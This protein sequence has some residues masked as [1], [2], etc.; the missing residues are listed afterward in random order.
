MRYSVCRHL[1][2]VKD[3]LLSGNFEYKPFWEFSINELELQECMPSE[4]EMQHTTVHTPTHT[5]D[6]QMHRN[7]GAVGSTL[8]DVRLA[9]GKCPLSRDC[10]GSV[11]QTYG[12]PSGKTADL[13]ARS[14]GFRES[15]PT[16]TLHIRRA[17]SV[18][19][20]SHSRSGSSKGPSDDDATVCN[21]PHS[22]PGI[23]H[24]SISY[25]KSG[26]K[27]LTHGDK[28]VCSIVSNISME[29]K[30]VDLHPEVQTA[31]RAPNA[32]ENHQRMATPSE[33]HGLSLSVLG[34]KSIEKHEKSVIRDI[35]VRTT[36]KEPRSWHV[37]QHGVG[38][39]VRGL[40]AIPENGSQNTLAHEINRGKQELSNAPSLL[41][42]RE[43][44]VTMENFAAKPQRNALGNLM[45]GQKSGSL[46]SIRAPGDTTPATK[47][48]SECAPVD[49]RTMAP[50]P[51][52]VPS[53]RQEGHA[54]TSTRR[55]VED[56]GM[57]MVRGI[58]YTKL[59]C[60][61]KGG[62]SKVYKVM[63]PNKKI[64]ALKRIRLNGR[65]SEAASGF[66]DEI[67]LLTRLKGKSNIIQLIDSE[68]HQKDGIIYMVLECGDIDLARLLQRHEASKQERREALGDSKARDSSVEVDE[69]FVRLYWEQMLLAVDT[70]HKE[71]I[72]HSDLKPANFLVVEGQLKLIDFGIAKAIQAGTTAVDLCVPSQSHYLYTIL[73][74]PYFTMIVD[75]T[76]IARE[77]QV[78]TL[79]YMSP[80]AITGGT[81]RG[82]GPP[83]KVGR[84]SDIWSLGCILYQMVY[85]K[86]PF[87]H[88]P[89]IQ[90]MHAIIDEKHDIKFPPLANPYLLHVIKRCLVRHPKSRIT[91]AELLDHPFLHPARTHESSLKEIGSVTDHVELSK[92]QLRELLQQIAA[93]GVNGSEVNSLSDKLFMQLANSRKENPPSNPQK[94]MNT[95]S[96]GQPRKPLQTIQHQEQQL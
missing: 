7:T 87:A 30:A 31:S 78:G 61:G 92:D 84:A 60:V 65:D 70:I 79:N 8:Q 69:N 27:T 47:K 76:S 73:I 12:M 40:G 21:D 17:T 33:K 16:P 26:Y 52:I 1:Q 67:T 34:D 44:P 81:P 50:P 18:H 37:G 10:I 53:G 9:S 90:K 74:S 63:A 20:A 86:T 49:A 11:G 4:S 75:T 89:F 35:G 13:V 66:L 91:M 59:E 22:T 25:P 56:E 5:S 62:S 15:H 42:R 48:P 46:P 96:T 95:S 57:V 14:L 3:S 71:R 77:S 29:K 28:T 55:I 64:F 2:S 93:S 38:C 6:T 72:V 24:Q 85:G 51:P 68:V 54:S 88:L 45:P 94:Q 83:T 80:E 36:E 41:E 19:S 32:N 58:R 23:G 43:T 82:G 39:P